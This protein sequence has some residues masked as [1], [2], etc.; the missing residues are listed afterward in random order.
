[1]SS[2]VKSLL[3]SGIAFCAMFMMS[4]SFV[5]K[6]ETEGTV[7]FVISEELAAKINTGAKASARTVTY[8]GA[9]DSE[10]LMD[11]TLKSDGE[12]TETA[13]VKVAKGS[14][15][16]FKSVP[17]D[18]LIYLEALVYKLEKDEDEN[19]LRTDLYKGTSSLIRVEADKANTV[20]LSLTKLSAGGT[21]SYTP[22]N[23][24]KSANYTVRE[25]KQTITDEG[26]VM[27][28][29]TVLTGKIGEQTSAAAAEY[30][31]FITPI[32]IEQQTIA[33]DG[34]TIVNLYYDR[35]TYTV[36]YNQNGHT[37]A[38]IP[39]STTYRYGAKVQTIFDTSDVSGYAIAGW[40]TDE[41]CTTL[42]DSTEE[43]SSSL[44]L[45]AKWVEAVLYG[46]RVEFNLDLSDINVTRT[47]ENNQIT[48]TAPVAGE[49]EADYTY[50]W[51]LDGSTLSETTNKLEVDTSSFVTGEPYDV[52]LY[53]TKEGKLYSAF[54][55]IIK[56]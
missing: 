53:L 15:V 51:K 49:G 46:I 25:W 23:S 20:T 48:F 12:F 6:P 8:S 47:V 43:I 44:T 19:L 2:K 18:S 16:E 13:T 11:I 22:V 31:G 54:F 36:T 26:Y 33:S 27:S 41:A 35:V 14:T 52:V 34:S 10:I 17:I 56:E 55:Q 42:Y 24:G 3:C 30:T 5:E 37:S 40:F 32:E 38:N 9:D 7:S 21:G 39:A 1:M 4:C 28:K 50:E 29:E 45:Y